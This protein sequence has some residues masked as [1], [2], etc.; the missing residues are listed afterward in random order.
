MLD[1]YNY[2]NNPKAKE[3]VE[4]MMLELGLTD[5]WREANPDCFWPCYAWK[6]GSSCCFCLFFAVVASLCPN[7]AVSL[8]F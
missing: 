6:V 2:I 3:S 7:P 8:S 5:I 1:I 4:N